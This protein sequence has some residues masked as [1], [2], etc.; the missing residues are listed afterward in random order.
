MTTKYDEE[1]SES[2]QPF[3]H[4]DI[5][6][7]PDSKPRI[8]LRIDRI[9]KGDSLWISLH[10]IIIL[11]YSVAFVYLIHTVKP[12]SCSAGKLQLPAREA[13]I[14]ELRRFN[15]SLIDNPFAGVPRPE[16]D[17]AWHDLVK[18]MVFLRLFPLHLGK[19]G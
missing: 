7:S 3:L 15:T 4:Q 2:S 8:P 17:S 6:L 11:S 18:S 9:W 16:L 1:R 12:S 19:L 14:P 5:K 10:L 13:L